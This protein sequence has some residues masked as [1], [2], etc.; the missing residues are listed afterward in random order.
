MGRNLDCTLCH[1]RESAEAVRDFPL[2]E[3]FR[4]IDIIAGHYGPG[5][6]VQVSGGEPT[7]R[8]EFVNDQGELDFPALAAKRRDLDAYVSLWP[9]RM[10]FSLNPKTFASTTQTARCG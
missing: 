7:L 2:E 6:D 8:A 10:P 1:L 9:T 4:H 3:I 5:T